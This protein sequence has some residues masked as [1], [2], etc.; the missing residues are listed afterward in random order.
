MQD[1]LGRNIDYI[2]ISVTD[3]CNLRCVYCMP[4]EGIPLKAHKD[5]LTYGEILRICRLLPSLGISKVKLTGGEPLVRR[6]LPYL[7]GEIRK[8]PGISQVTLTTNGILLKEQ[9]KELASAGVSAIN[10]SL[11]T[12][13][14]D[15][16]HKITR[17]DELDKVKDG[18]KAALAHPEIPLKVNCVPLG[19]EEQD[20]VEVAALA[21]DYPIHVR[22]IEM[23][24]IGCGKQYE[25]CSQETIMQRLEQ[26]YGFLRELGES[27]GNGPCRYYEAEGFAGKIGFISAVSHKFC[28]QCNRIRL[29]AEGFL[30]TC[31]QYEKGC[32]LRASLRKGCEDGELLDLM[33]GAIEE[34]PAE[35]QFL[36]DAI[37]QEEGHT[38]AE[39]GG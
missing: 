35:H 37:E 33:K 28:D 14:R 2:R 32:D 5:M 8:I 6:D 11:D 34:K 38:M 24:P 1:N 21:R 31:L 25:F 23:M 19:I 36:S 17:R 4:E 10:I 20:L 27:Y 3:R 7:I 13:D 22:F 39:I 26:R 9:M 12:L 16:Y 15:L 30:K 29:T 18:I